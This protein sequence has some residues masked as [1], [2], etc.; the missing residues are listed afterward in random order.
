[1]SESLKHS[2]DLDR[3]MA[4]LKGGFTTIVDYLMEEVLS[5]QPPEMA[6]LM[7]ATAIPDHFCA[8]L[9]DALYELDAAPGTG[10]MNGDEFIARLQKDNLFLIALDAENR[11]FR[12]HHLFRQLLR[13]QVNR[14]WRPEEIAALQSRANAWFVENDIIDNAITN[15]PAAFRESEYRTVPD[16][17]PLLIPPSA[18][19]IPPSDSP[20]PPASSSSSN[21]AFR[22]PNSTFHASPSPS[23]QPLVEPLS[24]RELDVLDLLAQR[25]SNKEI[26]EKMFISAETVKSHLKNIYQKLNV[27]KR[28]QAIEKA[29]K[30]GIL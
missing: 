6:R 23:P 26:S 20:H 18:F 16:P 29:K 5:H 10:E 13:D 19:P 21:S 12:Y 15:S 4:G 14:Y 11:W 25:L 30:I 9:C 28:R 3:L 8:P 22:I 24:N 17:N 27:S 7:T 1:M 2:G